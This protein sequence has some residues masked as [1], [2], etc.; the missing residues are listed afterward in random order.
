MCKKAATYKLQWNNNIIE[1]LQ[2]LSSFS[3]NTKLCLNIVHNIWPNAV[4]IYARYLTS[5]RQN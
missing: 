5:A 4:H 2:E 3:Q 1:L